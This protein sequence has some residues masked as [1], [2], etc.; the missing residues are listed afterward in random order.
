LPDLDTAIEAMRADRERFSPQAATRATYDTL[1]D[2]YRDLYPALRST[3]AA[4]ARV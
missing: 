2:V 3:F 4:L 1:F